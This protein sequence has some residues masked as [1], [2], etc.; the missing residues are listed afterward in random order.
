MSVNLR[1]WK[2]ED[3]FDL[4]A[5]INNKKVLDNLR[6]GIPFPYTEK[7][8]V[9]FITATLSAEKDSQYAFAITYD[10]KII[11]SVGVFRKENVH[12][13]TAELG[14]YIAEPYWGKGI[15]TESVRQMC[16]YIF[17]NTDIIRIF[18]EPYAHNAASCRVLEKAGFQ[19]E[20]L[21]RKNAI[22]N[23]QSVDMRMYAILKP[24]II[25]LL[26]KEDITPAMDMVWE[27]FSEFIA[28]DY[29]QQ[30]IDEF[31]RFIDPA[32]ITDKM[33]SGEFKLWGA[34]DDEK[35]VGIVAIGPPLRIAL[36]SVDKRY[37]RQG[38]ARKLF[39]TALADKSRTDGYD[40]I[41]VNASPYAVHIYRRLSFV[42]TNT[43]QTVNGLRFTPMEC[44]I[45]E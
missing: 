33:L 6:D 8:A 18:A 31:K 5:A 44:K 16:A 40:K 14:Y 17:E 34:F 19:F 37:Q 20:G 42:P 24:P 45:N 12:R 35:P 29:E 27:V 21:L 23:G 36:L 38:I 2:L 32:H 10:G 22:K 1:E 15:M 30:G 7:D 28:P 13:L 43:E 41:T 3:A 25:R 4:A 26:E 11:G 9:E 39:E